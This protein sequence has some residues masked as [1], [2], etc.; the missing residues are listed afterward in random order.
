[1][2]GW[3]HWCNGHEFEWTPGVGDG[4]GCL[5]YC[6]S[7]G[8][9][10]SDT[11]EQ[12]IWSDLICD[13]EKKS[14][15]I[16]SWMISERE[17]GRWY[18]SITVVDTNPGFWKPFPLKQISQHYVM[19]D[20]FLAAPRTSHLN[21]HLHSFIPTWV[22]GCCRIPGILQLLQKGDQVQCRHK[23]YLSEKGIFV[24]LEIHQ[25]RIQYVFR[26]NDNAFC[27]R[28]WFP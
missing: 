18:I 12:L 5:A 23:P 24:L 11:T 17:W 22:N 1:M 4:Q 27:S 9:K 16:N 25:Y 20:E 14:L 6:D 28:K 21:H 8:C 3:H 19:K 10:E 15:E 2:A 7:W 13:G 26:W